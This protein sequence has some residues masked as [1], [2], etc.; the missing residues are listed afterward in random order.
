MPARLVKLKHWRGL[1]ANFRPKAAPVLEFGAE[2]GIFF[3]WRCQSAMLADVDAPAVIAG[4]AH[5]SVACWPAAIDDSTA[6]AT[7]AT[8]SRSIAI[9]TGLTRYTLAPEASA[10]LRSELS[11]K[12]EIITTRESA[13]NV[14]PRLLS[15]QSGGLQS[16]R[17][18]SRPR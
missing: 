13:F 1:Q 4:P 14:W 11:S 9:V 16:R 12:A 18:K 8:A 2:G 6:T 10:C 17:R 3:H 7:S 15:R 5:G